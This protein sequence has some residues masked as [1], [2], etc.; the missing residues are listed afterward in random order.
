M[1]APCDMAGETDDGGET[2]PGSDGGGRAVAADGSCS[3]D[4][5]HR[6]DAGRA[7][8]GKAGGAHSSAAIAS[9]RVTCV[10]G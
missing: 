10:P 1:H 9:G 2:N 4:T 5:G 7:W 3:G 8:A 6:L